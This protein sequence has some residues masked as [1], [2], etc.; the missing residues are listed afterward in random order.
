MTL[1]EG[2]AGTGLG[3]ETGVM[4]TTVINDGAVHV[5]ICRRTSSTGAVD[6]YLDG[7]LE[8]SGSAAYGTRTDSNYCRIGSGSTGD[9]YTVNTSPIPAAFSTPEV[10]VFAS[11]LSDADLTLLQAAQAVYH[12]G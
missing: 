3:A 12:G 2:G 7:S 8:A 10:I 6:I 4:G 1:W 5:G 11:R 9:S